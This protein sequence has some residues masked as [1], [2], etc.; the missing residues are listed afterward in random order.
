MAIIGFHHTAISSP[1]L[2]RL[3]GF[4]QKCFGFEPVFQFA[5]EPGV[6]WIDRMMAVQRTG[7]R[8]VMLRLGNAFL[9][10]FQFSSPEPRAHDPDRRVIDHGFTHICFVVDNAATECARLEEFGV[11][12][13]APPVETGLP[14]TGTYGRDPDGN[15]FEILEI[16]DPKHPLDF[17]SQRLAALQARNPISP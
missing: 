8:V 12:L 5:W 1:D 6:E 7:A 3:A 9:E 2:N 17:G 15:V 13:H 4:Y 10:I 14:I 16:R 11:R